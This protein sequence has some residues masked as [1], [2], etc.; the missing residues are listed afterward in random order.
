M[1]R[2]LTIGQFVDLAEKLYDPEGDNISIL[3]LG[4]PGVGKTVGIKTLAQRLAERMGRKFLDLSETNINV[5]EIAEKIDQYFIF[6]GFSVTHVEPTDVSG[7]PR[8]IDGQYAS[9]L[10]LEYVYLLSLPD[11]AGI[12]FLDEITLDNRPD[13]RSAELKILDER[14]FGFKVLSPKVWIIAAG[15]TDEHTKLAEPIPDPILRGRVMRF[16]IKAPTVNEWIEYMNARYGDKWEKKI[17]AFLRR[18]P[19]AIWVEYE[20][21]A[22]YDPRLSPRTWTRLATTL[23]KL[24]DAEPEEIEA[25]VASLVSGKEYNLLMTFL[26]TAIPPLEDLL[27]NPL[28]WPELS[29]EAKYIIVAEMSNIAVEELVE[30]FSELLEVMAENDREFLELLKILIPKTRRAEFLKLV[31][32]RLPRVFKA[33]VAISDKARELFGD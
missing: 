26:T 10:P 21:D 16:Y 29:I 3:L 23:Y 22:G 6:V 33:F 4:P 31:K 27:K 18:Y 28:I 24:G 17:A 1:S 9:Y 30:K 2:G 11:A 32:L 5:K 7:F 14:Q 12:V 13:R 8:V 19:G 15:N 20:D 25:V